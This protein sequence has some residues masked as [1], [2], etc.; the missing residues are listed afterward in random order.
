MR[1]LLTCEFVQLF[2]LRNIL[3]L[4][5]VGASILASV[6]LSEA[7]VGLVIGLALFVLKSFFLYEAGRALIKRDSKGIARAIAAVSSF[8]RVVF[9]A[10]TLALVAQM[11]LS[12]LLSTFGGLVLGQINLHLA[13]IVRRKPTQC[14]NT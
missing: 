11:G 12:T 8:G 14:S 10:V 5:I 3:V 7:A 9:V 4:G 1:N 13:Y 2:R 6:G